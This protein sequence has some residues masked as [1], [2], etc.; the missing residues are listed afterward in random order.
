MSWIGVKEGI[1]TELVTAFQQSFTQAFWN[2]LNPSMGQINPEDV[3]MA[4][5][6]DVQT[7]YPFLRVEV[8][9]NAAHWDNI[10][11]MGGENKA[12]VA[13]ILG[14][15]TFSTDIYAL[16]AEARDKLSDGLLALLLAREGYPGYNVFDNL[17]GQMA[18]QGY[19]RLFLNKGT[20][21]LGTDDEGQGV[22]WEPDKKIYATTLTVGFDFAFS[23]PIEGLSDI[24]RE[25]DTQVHM[26]AGV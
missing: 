26:Q 2:S 13:G 15:G 11:M 21:T 9:I 1:K 12:D 8:L 25:I 24:I 5:Y 18:E 3:V 14:K 17:L 10:G 22:P 6:P 16:S 19:P 20:L 23:M 7:V 4:S